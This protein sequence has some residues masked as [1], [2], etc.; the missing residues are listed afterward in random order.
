[1]SDAVRVM[2]GLVLTA[3]EEDVVVVATELVLLEVT[4][5]A[6]ELAEPVEL[7]P[8]VEVLVLENEVECEVECEVE[9]EQCAD[10]VTVLVETC[11]EVLVAVLVT[12]L[13]TVLS[14]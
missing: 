11:V 13:V 3:E 4:E 6:E 14:L 5:L 8:G 2:V 12:V 9:L 1:L 7:E 10:T